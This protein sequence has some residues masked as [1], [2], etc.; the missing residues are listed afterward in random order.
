[1]AALSEQ[2]TQLIDGSV[3]AQVVL[4]AERRVLHYNQAYEALTGLRGRQLAERV[5][6]GARCYGTFT[7]AFLEEADPTTSEAF[8]KL[9][10]S[11]PRRK[12][13]FR[14]G[15]PDFE[16][17]VHLMITSPAEPKTK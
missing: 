10:A 5:R 17:H 2:I 6:A 8:V 4:D 9:W 16:K 15:Y 1:M 7:G 14:Y 13:P 3:D 12:L 11:Q